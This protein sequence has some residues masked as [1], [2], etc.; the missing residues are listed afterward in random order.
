[1]VRFITYYKKKEEK[2]ENKKDEKK[3]FKA[4]ISRARH[5]HIYD[6][7]LKRITSP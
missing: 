2:K 5:E 7:D 4:Y 1:M 3:R 6:R